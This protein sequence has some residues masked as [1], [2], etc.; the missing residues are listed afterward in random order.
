MASINLFNYLDIHIIF[1]YIC[2]NMYCL[3]SNYIP[4]A[5]L[6]PFVKNDFIKTSGKA[7]I[8]IRICHDKKTRFIST[9]YDIEPKFMSIDGLVKPS[10]PGHLKL[11]MALNKLMRQYNGILDDIGP[12]IISMDIN[13]LAIRLRQGEVPSFTTYAKQ[14]IKQLKKEKRFSYAES[15]EVTLTHLNRLSNELS[16]RDITVKFLN[17]FELDLK[18]H[19]CKTNSIRIYLNNIRAIFNHAL[20]NEIINLSSPFRKFKVKQEETGKRNISIEEIRKIQNKALLK[21]QE[22]SRDIFVLSL[23]LIGINLKDL[24]YLKPGDISGGRLYYRRSKTGTMYSIKVFPP[25]MKLIEKYRGEKYLLRFLD[26]DDSYEHYKNFLK[27][28]NKRLRLA[29]GMKISTY[30]SRHSWASIAS[31]LGISED[32]IAA[33]LGHKSLNRMTSIYINFDMNRVD[34]ANEKVIRAIT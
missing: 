29:T 14:R 32:V 24:L 10:Y 9:P 12:D 28:T 11:N 6:K 20:D 31:S 1:A 26:S 34:E 22:R 33:A 18:L 15:Y 13:S 21:A 27:E 3:Y 17:E 4:M 8:K 30:T 7:N 23:Y 2:S 5:T 25:A 16:F 19:G